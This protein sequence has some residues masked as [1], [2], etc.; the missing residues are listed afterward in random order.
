[1]PDIEGELTVIILKIA[2]LFSLQE[3]KHIFIILNFA[4]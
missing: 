4:T 3:K 2:V 1:M